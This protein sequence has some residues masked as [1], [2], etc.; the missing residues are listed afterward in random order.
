MWRG[1][2]KVYLTKAQEK[3]LN[4]IRGNLNQQEQE[5][6]NQYDV[7]KK[8]TLSVGPALHR[9]LEDILEVHDVGGSAN[10]PATDDSE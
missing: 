7:L 1:E 9:E 10:V 4:S 6:V 2:K 8:N 3:V 5:V